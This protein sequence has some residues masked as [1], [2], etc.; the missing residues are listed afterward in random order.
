MCIRDSSTN[1][2]GDGLFAAVDQ[3]Q[4]QIVESLSCNSPKNN[5][6]TTD[7]K[8]Y[9]NHETTITQENTNAT[10]QVIG[11]IEENDQFVVKNV[12]GTF[13]L[14]DAVNSNTEIDNLTFN[15]TVVANVGDE[16]V[17]QVQSGGVA[18][19]VAIGK[20]LRNVLTKTL[21]LSNCNLQTHKN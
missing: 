8:L 4:G 3:I 13:N 20:V 12:S 15:G 9:L 18:H 5:Y 6:F 7:A 17:L 19:E 2:S 14:T 21:L 16:V 1:D 11:Q 10:A